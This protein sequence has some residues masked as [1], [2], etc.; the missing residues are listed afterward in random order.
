MGRA[1]NK[2]GVTERDRMRTASGE[3]AHIVDNSAAAKSAWLSR[4]IRLII[5]CGIILV[6]AVIAATAGLLL[7]LRDRDLADGESDL[8][9]LTLVLAEQIDQTFQ[10]VELIQT[11][12]VDRMQSL[13]I[14]SAE[15]LKREMSGYDIHQRLKYQISAL[16]YINA[17]VLTD[18]EGK[19]INF[20]RSWPVPNVIRPEQDPTEAFKSDPQL[21]TFVGIPLRSPV[22]GNWVIPISRKFTGPDGKFL[23]VVIGVIEAQKF[24]EYF[25]AI[26]T[27]SDQSIL[28]FR[29]DGKMLVRYPRLDAVV[30][31]PLPRSGLFENQ[32]PK[33]DNGTFRQNGAIDGKDRLISARSLIHYPIMVVV[34]TS[35]AD[36][37]ANW[38][39]GAITMTGAA[40]TLGFLIGGLVIVCVWQVGK[41]FREKNFQRDTA[42]EN[43]S[44]G[45]VMFDSAA[46]LVMCNDR[47]RQIYNMSPDST[48][49]GC[50]V[51]DLL[52][53][54]VANGTFSGN[55]EKF[56]DGLL[57]TIA[58]GET[59]RQE[60]ETGDGRII[61]VVN[62]PMTDGG[63]VATH[64]DIT[65]RRRNEAIIARM[66]HYDALTGLPNR[67]LFLEELDRA[68]ALV[69]RGGNFALLYLDLDQF[70]RVNDTLGHII[71]D[72]LLKIVADRL[73]GCIRDTDLI[74]R[75]GGDEFAIIQ[76]SL[77]PSSDPA[78][79]AERIS[80]ALK[81]PYDIDG[82]KVVA[83]VSIGIAIA[84]NDAAERDQLVKC[85]DMALYGAKGG[86]RGTYCFYEPELDARVKARHQLDTDLRDALVNGEFELYYQPIVNL[87]TNQVSSC[88]ALLRWH[89]PER[90][91]VPPGEFIPVAEENGLIV[92]LGEWVLRQACADAATWP[93]G[94][95]VAVNLSPA[96]LIGSKLLPA[97][98]NALASSGISASRLELEITE[99]VLMRN[100]FASLAMLHQLRDIGAR[101]AMDDFGTGYSSL[102]Y[103]RSFPFDKI[104]IDRSFIEGISE[105]NDCAAI[106]EA[107]ID[108][109]QRLNMTTTAEG[110]ETVEQREKVRE[111]GCTE[112]QGYLFSRPKPLA[113]ILPLLA[114]RA[115]MVEREAS[116]A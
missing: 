49:P 30:G 105:E 55:P 100:T 4:P 22:T 106:V 115:E 101:I 82:H 45:L 23:G 31:Q 97:V 64:E 48:K 62:Q 58:Q 34:T 110:I 3:L 52:N 98:V 81:A 61:S 86:G 18:A 1:S 39:R 50:T 37:L 7:N 5:I 56:V 76:T 14:A 67:A 111:L 13:G 92:P 44:Q 6:G 68:L 51:L 69:Q 107:V 12:V 104:K 46:R 89:H 9:R 60:V 15:D 29:R 77:E 43:M 47:Y 83:G 90:G 36:T 80:A 33:F 16:P 28:L 20:S 88:E 96:Q 93:D 75:L 11:A 57:A 10:S 59:A 24:E 70:K 42:L 19:L 116:A 72:E 79:L 40:L 66:A 114:P 8:S 113:E 85:A 53:S 65:E 112:L 95:K 41:K 27:A 38:R 32:R 17:I 35:V 74:A 78:V 94:I 109:A 102:S 99:T 63:W 73:C 21:N 71:G 84:P 103:L 87:Q 2:Y 108:M 54:R 91:L 25:K 26:T